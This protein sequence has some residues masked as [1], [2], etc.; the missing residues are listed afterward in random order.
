MC[1]CKQ[2]Q[3]FTPLVRERLVGAFG[4]RILGEVASGIVKV[5]VIRQ[6]NQEA[7]EDVT[8]VRVNGEVNGR[9]VE[10]VLFQLV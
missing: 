8:F 9:I 4:S 5:T 7:E 2:G 6:P 10:D 3:R 1:K